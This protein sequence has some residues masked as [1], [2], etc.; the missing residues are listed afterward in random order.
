[1]VEVE[2]MEKV[3]EEPQTQMKVQDKIMQ[4]HKIQVSLGEEKAVSHNNHIFDS[5]TLP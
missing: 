2:K 4:L 3:K 5:V 1:M